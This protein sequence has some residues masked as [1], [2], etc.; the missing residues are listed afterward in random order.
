MI[1]LSG[2]ALLATVRDQAPGTLRAPLTVI[3][4]VI[5]GAEGRDVII[6]ADERR[7]SGVSDYLMRSYLGDSSRAFSVYVGYYESQRQGKTIHSPKNCLPGSG[8][9]VLSATT[10]TISTS[11]GPRVVNH[12][13]LTNGSSQA[14]VYYWYQGRGRVVADEYVVKWN[15]LRDAMFTRRT[16]EALV[17]VIVPLEN[18]GRTSE[19][20]VA[21]ED[22]AAALAREV[23]AEL[24]PAVESALP[25]RA[26]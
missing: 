12:Y 24:I 19:S 15:L 7:V 8:W 26:T 1:L 22:R 11:L 20:A 21:I 17:R 13:L 16:E 4:A 25:A 9:S 6:S 5:V 14:L 10:D 3:P 18:A 2:C 23:S